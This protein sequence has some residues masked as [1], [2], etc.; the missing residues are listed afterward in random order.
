M[1][2]NPAKAIIKILSG[3]TTG[4]LQ[5]NK[6]K[7]N[8][9]VL[10]K[11]KAALDQEELVTAGYDKFRQVEIPVQYNPSSL[12]IS[13]NISELAS[14]ASEGLSMASNVSG[15]CTRSLSVDLV[16][17]REDSLEKDYVK[18]RTEKFLALM[19]QSA[20]RRISFSWAGMECVGAV[21]SLS[22]SYDM[23]DEQGYPIYGTL[24]LTVREEQS[25]MGSEFEKVDKPINELQKRL[26]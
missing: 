24:K 6:N 20:D 3:D 10:E 18:N 23:F 9:N 11:T 21:T 12:G 1:K 17:Y 5:T 8:P 2:E 4:S 19:V 15:N 14:N 26:S 22:V 25:S 13:V 16:F 7:R